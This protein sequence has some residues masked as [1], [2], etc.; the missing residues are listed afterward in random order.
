MASSSADLA[1][2]GSG[3]GGGGLRDYLP[4]EARVAWAKPWLGRLSEL[5]KTTALT[6]E[7]EMFSIKEEGI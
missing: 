5:E 3:V 4:L 7:L 1:S 6:K 2:G